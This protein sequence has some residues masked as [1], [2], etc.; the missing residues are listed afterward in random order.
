MQ[1]QLL[2][3]SSSD[4][5]KYSKYKKEYFRAILSGHKQNELRSL[6]KLIYY[7]DKINMPNKKYK[8]ELKKL[9]K[10]VIKTL[11]P[12]IIKTIKKPKPK[13]KL[14]Q[15][16]KV[17][18]ISKK[19]CTKPIKSNINYSKKKSDTIKSI[20]V[21]DNSIIID[22]KSNINKKFIKFTEINEKGYFRDNF[23]IKGK[24]FG[25]NKMKL[26]MPQIK[27]VKRIA[28]YK[29]NKDTIKVSL[30]A[31]KN[32]KTIYVIANKRI[33]IKVLEKSKANTK[34]LQ[35]QKYKNKIIVIDP[36]HGGKDSG[37]TGRSKRYEKTSV[38]KVGSKLY[39][40]LK[41]R[42][43]TVYMTRTK[44][45][46]RSLRY[47][48][49]Y[50]NKKKAHLFISIHAN[51]VPNRKKDKVFGIETYYLSPARSE[52]AKRVAAKENKADMKAMNYSS[53]NTLLMTQN[54]AKITAS[55][56]LALDIQNNILHKL[57]KHYKHIKDNGVRK[58]PFWILIG[59][60]M[61]S[62]LVEIG[63]IS[64]P[65]ESKR[66]YSPY[67]QK[68]LAI[69]IANGIDSYFLKNK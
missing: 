50:A 6:K 48:T 42:G 67:Y 24:F 2:A 23:E 29:K 41:S 37:A 61:P 11:K 65:R 10:K 44:D 22:F 9:E 27:V 64:H 16:K 45:K 7:S 53:K 62:V 33:I 26:K 25:I 20:I 32:L 38:L 1:L 66:L 56:K 47:R 36:G 31:K 60:Q 39:N 8:K 28:I 35:K 18:K 68:N 57:K 15:R 63:Y 13:T 4:I 43:Y 12:K 54:R 55:N 14:F 58:G 46:Y 30:R 40:I 3:A 51:A 21:Q 69:G 52:R 17:T 59:A 34:L 19:V 49:K 5:S